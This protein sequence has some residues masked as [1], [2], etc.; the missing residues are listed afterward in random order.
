M[1][2]GYRTPRAVTIS[3]VPTSGMEAGVNLVRLVSLTEQ[4]NS[5]SDN[6]SDVVSHSRLSSGLKINRE[7]SMNQKTSFSL[8][9]EKLERIAEKTING[10]TI[11]EIVDEIRHQRENGIRKIS[12]PGFGYSKCVLAKE[13]ERKISQK[14]MT[15]FDIKF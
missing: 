3:E 13:N 1:K 12:I 6:L 2:K 11:K 9:P 5:C 8:G 7:Q 10:L 4:E 15:E 14:R